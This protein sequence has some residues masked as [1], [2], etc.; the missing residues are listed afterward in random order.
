LSGDKRLEAGGQNRYRR[1]GK[2]LIGPDGGVTQRYAAYFL[3]Y[4]LKIPDVDG[5]LSVMS[6]AQF[7]E[8]M[9]FLAIKNRIDRGEP[10]TGGKR[11]EAEAEAGEDNPNAK[12]LSFF[13]ALGAKQ[14]KK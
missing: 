14:R 6:M 5:M 3:A 11:K 8:W 1:R 4:K 13:K 12:V 7:Q 10:A 2:K 9:A